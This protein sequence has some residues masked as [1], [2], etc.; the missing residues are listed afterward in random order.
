[1]NEKE[2]AAFVEDF[3][4]KH[5]RDTLGDVANKVLFENDRVR[6]WDMD[7]APGTC[8]D[9]HRHDLDYMLIILEGDLV[10]GIPAPGSGGELQV[11]QVQNGST[12]FIP[13]GG[14]EWA[15]NIGKSRYREILIELLEESAS[16]PGALQRAL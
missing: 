2:Q 6:I 14:S 1:M 13:R 7:L 8:S 9:L 12:F 16:P 10:A 11:A 4:A 3:L 15:V 5:Q